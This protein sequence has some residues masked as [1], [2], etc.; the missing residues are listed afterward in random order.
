MD[1][2]SNFD[3]Y[4]AFQLSQ[5]LEISLREVLDNGRLTEV[6]RRVFSDM[7]L[8]TRQFANWLFDLIFKS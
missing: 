2:R 6:E 4:E 8:K 7:Q 5:K 1:N 3:K